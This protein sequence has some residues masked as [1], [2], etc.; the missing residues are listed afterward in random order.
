MSETGRLEPLPLAEWDDSLSHIKHQ[1]DGR[2]LNIHSLLANHPELL[3]AWWGFRNY[4]VECGELGRRRGELVILR[5]A[6]LVG[7]M[8]EWQAH[9]VRGVDAGLTLEEIDRVKE[10]G[11]ASGWEPADAIL[12]SAVDELLA[13]QRLSKQMQGQLLAHFSKKQIMDL[14]AVQGMYTI[15]GCLVNTWELELDPGIEEQ[16]SSLLK[17]GN[18]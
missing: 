9:T 12:L 7:A 18:N 10:G 13:S 11:G 15:I 8:Y 3:K 5:V 16:L 6:V 4:G 17:T 1:M 2:P 14:I